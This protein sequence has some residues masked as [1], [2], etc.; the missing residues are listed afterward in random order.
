MKVHSLTGCIDMDRMYRAFR[1]V[2]R[3]RGTAGIDK[4]SLQMFEANLDQNLAA[5]MS[6]LKHGRY[7]AAPLRRS[8]I[9]KGHGKVR[10]LGIP[11]VRD[12][13]AQQVIRS[14]LEPIFEPT[15]AEDSYGFRPGRNAHQAIQRLLELHHLGYQWV[16][17]ADIKGFF[18][19]IPHE[20]IIDLVAERV[21]DGNILRILRE[22]LTAGVWED[23]FL[24]PTTQGTPQ[25]G[26]I[27]PLLA[28]I[29]LDVLDQRLLQAGFR[30]VRYA[31]DF[32]ILCP[33][34]TTAQRALALVADVVQNELGLA[35]SPEKTRLT[36][37]KHGFPFL[38]FLISSWS[39]SIR[40]KS[41]AKLK[42]NIRQMTIRSH[43]LSAD[44]IRRLNRVILGFA[45]YFATPFSSVK[46]QFYRLDGWIRKRL[47]CMKFKRISK[48]DNRR[49]LNRHLAHLGLVSFRSL[50]T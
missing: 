25:G 26:V 36:T 32:V 44:A 16:V 31:D 45:N 41:V 23:G 22:F 48:Y 2:K 37:F 33:Y 9:P 10:P 11:T 50:V 34:R 5:L 8:F 6:D 43:N 14:L 47:R 20:L 42:D 30:F 38:G 15:F 39:V 4:V 28:N 35:L 18:D 21:A 12:R 13:V 24:H 49:L 3:N 40:A 46:R 27:S 17:D 7:R 29:V 19:H 1:A